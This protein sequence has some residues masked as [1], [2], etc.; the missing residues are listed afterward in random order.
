MARIAYQRVSTFD[1]NLG[2]QEDAF[3]E[4]GIEKVFSDKASG[5]TVENRTGL[6]E[7]LAYA[8]EGD[9]LY[10]ESIS[11]LARN[12]KDLLTLVETLEAKKVKLISLKER[13]D[14]ASPTGVFL[15]QIIASMA[16]L[17]RSA[18]LEKQK[19]GIIAARNRGRHLGRPKVS[20][21]SEWQKYFSLWKSGLITAK[22]AMDSLHLSRT[23]FYRL[24][25]EWEQQAA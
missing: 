2:R 19:E 13:I 17:E 8:R 9:V 18:M 22:T 3:A 21:P 11:R 5:K 15:L 6:A 24:V 7:L 1:Q 12:V 25:K 23:T 10:I 20:H 16:E 14:T 4:L